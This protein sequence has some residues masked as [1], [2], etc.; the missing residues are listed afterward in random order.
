M[1]IPTNRVRQYYYQVVFSSRT[2]RDG[3]GTLQ[4]SRIFLNGTYPYFIKT[5]GVVLQHDVNPATQRRF[6]RSRR[7]IFSS[8]VMALPLPV[9]YYIKRFF[10]PFTLGFIKIVGYTMSL[11]DARTQPLPMRPCDPPTANLSHHLLCPLVSLCL[12]HSPLV[13]SCVEK[14]TKQREERDEKMEEHGVGLGA[15]SRGLF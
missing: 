7:P 2:K 15:S 6:A 13:P 10:S 4:L 14:L 3:I 11:Q 1:Y 5:K 8:V 12:T 9:H